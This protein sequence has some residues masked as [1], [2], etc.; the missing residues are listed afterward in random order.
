MDLGRGGHPKTPRE[1]Q[2][3]DPGSV[4]RE[5]WG[6]MGRNWEKKRGENEEK[7]REIGKEWREIGKKKRGN[8]GGKC[9][10]IGKIRREWVRKGVEEGG[11]GEK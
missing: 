11:K 10:E 6:E 5:N 1:H 7:Q 4:E 2:G 9:E 8:C 3:P